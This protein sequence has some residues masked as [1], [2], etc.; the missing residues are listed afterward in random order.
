M[1]PPQPPAVPS[2]R[3]ATLSGRAI[4]FHTAHSNTGGTSMTSTATITSV[5]RVLRQ[6]L[7]RLRLSHGNT[8]SV[9]TGGGR[10]GNELETLADRAHRSRIAERRLYQFMIAA[11]SSDIV[12]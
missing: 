3:H 4:A 12:R 9:A 6:S 8:P 11:V 7:N 5:P 1:T 2:A 10:A